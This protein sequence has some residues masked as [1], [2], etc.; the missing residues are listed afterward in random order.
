MN[1]HFAAAD[2]RFRI[3]VL[4]DDVLFRHV[5]TDT[6]A[7]RGHCCFSAGTIAEARAIL[8]R[9][10]IELALIDI[11]LPD[12]AGDGFCREIREQ[13]QD[14]LLLLMTARAEPKD[15]EPAS[16]W[17]VDDFFV[18]LNELDELWWRVDLHLAQAARLRNRQRRE[19][20]LRGLAALAPFLTGVWE[21]VPLLEYAL[22]LLR[23]LPEVRAVRVELDSGACIG[24]ADLTENPSLKREVVLLGERGLG[25]LLLWLNA[26]NPVDPELLSA[27][28]GI[29]G[30][31][32]ASAQ[33]FASLKERQIRLER[34]YLERQRQ[35]ARLTGRMDRLTEARDSFLALVSHDLRS[36]ISVVLGHCQLMEEGLLNAAQ[37]T[38]AIDTIRRQSERM[39]KMVENL[40]DRYRQGY[41]GAGELGSADL[42]RILLDMA[43]TFEP[44]AGRRRQQ[45]K[46]NTPGPVPV[47][48]DVAS[49]CEVL[50]NLIENALRYSPENSTVTLSLQILADQVQIQVQDEGPGFSAA[51][52]T[53]GPGLGYRACMRIVAASGGTIR[54]STLMGEA[55]TPKGGVV[56]VLLPLPVQ[57]GDRIRVDILCGDVNRLERMT[58]ALG[59]VWSC[60]TYTE[61]VDAMEAIRR[62]LPAV[63][64]VDNSTRD[65][66]GFLEKLKEDSSLGAIP[67]VMVIPA[68]QQDQVEAALI[69]GVLAVVQLPLDVDE[70]VAMVRRAVR[71]TVEARMGGVGRSMDGLTGLELPEYLETSL[72]ALLEECRMAG[73][74][75][76]M[77]RISIDDLKGTN[78]AHG[79]VVGDQL[80]IW[81]AGQVRER[82]GPNDLCVRS[83]GATFVWARPGRELGDTREAGKDL[84]L[85]ISR[86]RPR[87]GISRIVVQIEVDAVDATQL[88]IAELMDW[89][90]IDPERSKV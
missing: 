35:L 9:E 89:A 77:L 50:A 53:L 39:A 32:L 16:G 33:I 57:N 75:L 44:V 28:G 29:L 34:G 67:V 72:P 30:S 13:N 86:A 65:A 73:R 15:P 79:W 62:S 68:G 51:P 23:H 1:Q 74:P 46:V 83:G 70:L 58:E 59:T 2:T 12:G 48:I 87:L 61:P 63:L 71:M 21:P 20:W 37:S 36:P 27:L 19:G 14:T 81:L 52:D 31:S 3:L 82:A 38:K 41:S 85:A 60:A 56:T 11:F 80:L 66:M 18:K 49:I 5:V 6:L 64:V 42:S 7:E 45:I 78:R 84:A 25:R 4:D 24:D 47:E 10:R 43:D 55:G 40:L 90:G 26:E 88:N 17:V 22:P 8:A 54:T 69:Q 76:P